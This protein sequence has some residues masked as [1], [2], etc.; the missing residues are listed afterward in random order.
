MCVYSFRAMLDS[1]CSVLVSIVIVIVISGNR[2][3]V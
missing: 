1:K 2:V 3:S